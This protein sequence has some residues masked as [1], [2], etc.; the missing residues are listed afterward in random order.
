[1]TDKFEISMMGEL[2]FFLGLQ[3][4]H[5]EGGT[6]INQAKYTKELLKKF[7]MKSYSAD[8]TPMRSSIKLEKDEDGKSVDITAY[9]GIIGS[10]LYITASQPDIL[11]AVGV[12]GRFQAN[13]KQAHYTAAKIILKYL[14]ETQDLGLCKK[15][16]S[17]ATSTAEAEYL[18]A[19]SFYAQLL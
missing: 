4:R 1:M 2:N 3:V 11:F 14:K 5:I 16:T 17:V 18:A 15:Q 6:F 7:G 12:C 8:L 10:L 13:P 9:R 19:G